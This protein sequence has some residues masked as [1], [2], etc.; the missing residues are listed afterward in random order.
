MIDRGLAEAF[1]KTSETDDVGETKEGEAELRQLE[2]SAADLRC[3][4]KGDEEAE[5][6]PPSNSS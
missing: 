3:G 2:E 4:K 5:A 1:E 6:I